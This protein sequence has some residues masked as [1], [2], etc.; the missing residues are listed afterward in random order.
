MSHCCPVHTYVV[1]VVEI[2]E[3]LTGELRAVIRDNGVGYSKSG[4]NICEEQHGLFGLDSC[5][6]LDLDLLR[7]LVDCEK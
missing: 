5:D 4:D 7:K 1:S 2:Q 3:L 6:G